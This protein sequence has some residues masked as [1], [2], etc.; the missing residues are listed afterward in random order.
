M[1]QASVTFS[2]VDNSVTEWYIRHYTDLSD[3]VLFSLLRRKKRR[4]NLKISANSAN[5]R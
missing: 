1:R 2:R 4:E 5:L 3:E